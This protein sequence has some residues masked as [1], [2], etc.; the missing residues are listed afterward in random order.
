[1]V[2][3]AILSSFGPYSVYL[4]HATCSNGVLVLFLFLKHSTV[5]S[6]MGALLLYLYL[7]SKPPSYSLAKQKLLLVC[8]H[9]VPDITETSRSP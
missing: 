7:C 6:S 1:M 9:A 4:C 2:L 5:H 8:P 3:R